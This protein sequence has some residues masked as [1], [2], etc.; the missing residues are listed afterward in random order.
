MEIER[1]LTSGKKPDLTQARVFRAKAAEARVPEEVPLIKKLNENI[2]R[3]ESFHQ[4]YSEYKQYKEKKQAGNVKN[5]KINPEK[6]NSQFLK[7]LLSESLVLEIDLGDI[8]FFDADEIDSD[9]TEFQ[10]W[11]GQ[12]KNI[13]DKLEKDRNMFADT[14]LR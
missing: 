14:K 8:G 1:Q 9:I 10:E 11:K 7:N 5:L 12:A 6:F 3:C 2:Y 4:S 13:I